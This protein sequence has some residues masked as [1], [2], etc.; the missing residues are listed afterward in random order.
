M[1]IRDFQPEDCD[2]LVQIL[3][4]NLQ[5]GDPFTEGSDA[6]LR[7]RECVA[8]V[9]PVCTMAQRPLSISCPFTQSISAAEWERLWYER[10]Q[11]ASRLVGPPAWR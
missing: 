10:R 5:Y 8:A 11:D 4:A 1:V 9:F 3:K 7:V 6:M 2:A